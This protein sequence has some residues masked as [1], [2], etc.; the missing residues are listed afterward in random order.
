[1]NYWA[2]Y[3]VT[4]VRL[5]AFI[6]HDSFQSVRRRAVFGYTLCEPLDRTLW[7]PGHHEAGPG[8]EGTYHA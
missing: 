7:V 6:T 5:V 8:P 2:V 4:T 1:M 3:D